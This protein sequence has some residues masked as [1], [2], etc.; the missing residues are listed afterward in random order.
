MALNP[1]RGIPSVNEILENPVLRRLVDRIS[2][3]TVVTTV[4]NVLDE[5]RNE[6]HSAA[7]EKTLPS[8]SELAERIARRVLETERPKIRPVINA[9]GA[10]LDARLG[11][12]PLAEVAL[13]EI[14]AVARDYTSVEV[15]LAHGQPA[16]RMADVEELL[17]ELTGAEAA[18]VVNT[19]PGAT[20][21]VLAALA[22][23]RAVL[24]SR[25]QLAEGADGCRLHEI[26]TASGA[27]LCE[28][29]SANVTRL[30]DYERAIGAQTAALL[31]AAPDD[32]R[33]VGRTENVALAELVE[34]ARR[35][36]L[37]VIHDLGCGTLT[38]GQPFGL[39]DLPGVAESLKAGADLVMLRGDGL[40]GGPP[41]GILVGRR[42]LIE[43]V[44][45]HPLAG[46]LATD[47]RTL[48]ALAATL[49]LHR[50][51]QQ[52]RLDVPLLHLLTTSVENLK[53]RASRLA[54]QVAASGLLASAEAVASIAHLGGANVPSQELPTWC[55]ALVPKGMSVDRLSTLLRSGNPPIVGR[56]QED[57]LLLDL[58]SVIPRQD[59]DL[60]TA[61]LAL[62][63]TPAEEPPG[64]P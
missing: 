51:P 8:V 57:R 28:I 19:K 62:D 15:D 3:N 1:L 27:L 53:N 31:V 37:S 63:H 32:F 9:T 47:Q 5:V 24:V 25:G 4:R 34:L 17:R 11:P 23:G 22:A 54:P 60:V 61:V 55:V 29:G 2:R 13:A 49:R 26:V 38:D 45:K 64:K 30:D 35:R 46:A 21:L 48:A 44:E 56:Q 41:C 59:Q 39:R 43:S 7:A 10:L 33:V 6:V 14:V 42:T 52:A 18:M 20:M 16:R 58:R 50:D 40:L 36:G 12:A